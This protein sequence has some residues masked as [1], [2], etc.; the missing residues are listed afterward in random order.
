VLQL[1]HERYG[2]SGLKELAQDVELDWLFYVHSFGDTS[3][4]VG[5][6][7]IPFGIYN[8]IRDVGTLL[9]FYRPPHNFYGEGAYNSDTLEGI[10]LSHTF[11]LGAGWGLDADLHYGAWTFMQRDFGGTYLRE[12][13]ND[14]LGV[15][16]WLDTPVSGLRIGAGRMRY[17]ITGAVA[18][19][20]RWDVSHFSLAGDF[21]RFAVHGELKLVEIPNLGTIELLLPPS[22]I[23]GHTEAHAERAEGPRLFR[24]PE[25]A[26]EYLDDD[27]ALGA[28]FAFLPA[29]VMKAEHHWKQGTGFWYEDLLPFDPTWVETRYWIVS[30]STS[31]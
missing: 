13:V 15:E 22:G 5:R 12:N 21:E 30:L 11:S 9:P 25:C 28:T 10:V 1:S 20:S 7:P 8:E 6:V 19:R 23:Q 26:V 14:S 27:R 16:L 24:Q 2:A 31:F 4:K 17:D 3:V 18:G 29:L